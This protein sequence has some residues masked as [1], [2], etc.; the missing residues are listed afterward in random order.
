[1]I[2]PN[3]FLENYSLFNSNLWKAW[4]TLL[5]YV[6]FCY[7]CRCFSCC[8]SNNNNDPT[9]IIESG[10]GISPSINA[11]ER[12]AMISFRFWPGLHSL[13][14]TCH[15]QQ[16]T[17]S[18]SNNNARKSRNGRK[19]WGKNS[20]VGAAK[21]LSELWSSL[22][23]ALSSTL[24]ETG[25]LWMRRVKIYLYLSNTLGLHAIYQKMARVLIFNFRSLFLHAFW[26]YLYLKLIII[27]KQFFFPC[28]SQKAAERMLHLSVYN[29]SLPRSFYRPTLSR[30]ASAAHVPF[31]FML[32]SHRSPCLL[33]LQVHA[34]CSHCNCNFVALGAWINF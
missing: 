13:R 16:A 26:Y 34:F 29:R 1:V 2:I 28:G 18:S 21:Q 15:G 7:F 19:K 10:T 5:C 22:C 25:Q 17:G 31:L 23:T 11:R 14:N 6:L 4:Y 32:F 20:S 3:H 30:S 33:L 24:K 12:T 8:S 9:P 27:A